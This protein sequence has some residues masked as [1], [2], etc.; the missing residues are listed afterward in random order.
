MILCDTQGK[1]GRGRGGE[2]GEGKRERGERRE[3]KRG[4]EERRE[5]EVEAQERRG[6][7]CVSGKGRH[8]REVREQRSGRKTWEEKW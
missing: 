2:R 4:E 5:E 6:K 7:Q 1:R 3:G 8:G